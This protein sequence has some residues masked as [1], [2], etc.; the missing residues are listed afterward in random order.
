MLLFGKLKKN[1]IENLCF[2]F[3]PIL[4]FIQIIDWNV[5]NYKKMK[6]ALVPQYTHK[7]L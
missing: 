2:L 3:P 1:K 5:K 6:S 4:K 7:L